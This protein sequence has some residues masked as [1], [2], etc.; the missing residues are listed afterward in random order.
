[1]FLGICAFGFE[2]IPH[3]S[4]YFTFI[5]DKTR[6]GPVIALFSVKI[7]NPAAFLTYVRGGLGLGIKLFS[8]FV[9]D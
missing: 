2:V 3:P 9:T 4:C 6:H 5:M 7:E 1:M 8:K